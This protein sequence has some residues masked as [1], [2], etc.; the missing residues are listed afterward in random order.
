[1]ICFYG[2]VNAFNGKKAGY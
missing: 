1:M 2:R